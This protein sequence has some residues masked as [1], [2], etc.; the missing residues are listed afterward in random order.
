MS[1]LPWDS[2]G[3]RSLQTG[4]GKLSPGKRGIGTQRGPKFGGKVP[5]NV[6]TSNSQLLNSLVAAGKASYLFD[7]G[8]YVVPAGNQMRFKE[9]KD[10][11]YPDGSGTPPWEVNSNTSQNRTISA[12]GG[13]C[14]SRGYMESTSSTVSETFAQV[15]FKAGADYTFKDN[16]W[17]A[18]SYW[19]TSPQTANSGIHT[20]IAFQEY[21]ASAFS[22]FPFALRH[23]SGTLALTLLLDSGNDFT[24]DVSLACGTL[25][26][27]Q[28]N[29]IVVQWGAQGGAASVW[30]NG[31][32]YSTTRSFAWPTPNPQLLG[33]QLL[34]SVG[35]STGLTQHRALG[36]LSDLWVGKFTNGASCLLTDDEAAQLYT[37]RTTV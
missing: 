20:I 21:W 11:T 14:S 33:L 4:A 2:P 12:T 36:R 15:Y 29:H 25:T 1:G 27:G 7:L 5:S 13:V 9:V 34:S 23:A 31:T 26:A 18:F 37:L 32:K 3:I 28:W 10:G 8:A 30:L 16:M 24:A 17:F 6:P 22:R 35:N 19:P